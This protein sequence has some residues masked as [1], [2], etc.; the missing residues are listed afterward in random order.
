M[1]LK[2]KTLIILLSLGLIACGNQSKENNNQSKE[3]TVA[4]EKTEDN[5]EA[6]SEDNSE[7]NNKESEKESED[8]NK[9][10]SSEDEDLSHYDVNL[11]M[12]KGPTSAGA[13]NMIA[14]SNNDDA[15]FNFHQSV[16]GA[17]DAVIPKL[18]S[19]EA[20]VAIIPPNLASAVYNKSEGKIKV[21]AINNL[22]VLYLVESKDMDINSID[23]LV[24][25][26]ET[27]YAS[28]KGATPDL[29][30][31]EV[32]KANGY[33]E[34][35]LK[36]EF[37]AEASEVAQKMISGQAKVALLPEP[38]VTSVLKKSDGA[39]VALDINDLYEKAT[40]S[41]L[42]SAVLVARSEYLDN[43]DVDLLLE[44]YRKSI[45]AATS[46]VENTAKLLEEYDIMPAAIG[47]EALDK[48]ALKYIDGQEM[49][50]MM[51]KHLEDLYNSNPQL[52]GGSLPDDDFYYQK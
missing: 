6:K 47:K 38:M 32:L 5:T 41:P 52:V 12:L 13:I 42:I 25:S 26:G 48:L 15:K 28:G 4:T 44:T 43:I 17:P 30:I 8:K 27:I 23:D 50:T 2:N 18:V 19:G 33:K 34:D 7:E 20:D 40:D 14:W 39:K 21:L 36:I 49:K 37:L 3:E 11:A 46:D 10:E 35:D 1:K 22:G 29:A 9:E 51:Q 24:N 16:E 45:E 31:K